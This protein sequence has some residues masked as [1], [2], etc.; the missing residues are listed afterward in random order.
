MKKKKEE[1]FNFLKTERFSILLSVNNL[2]NY[3]IKSEET[4]AKSRNSYQLLIAGFQIWRQNA[5][6]NSRL[7]NKMS[8]KTVY[9]LQVI[10]RHISTRNKD[11][12]YMTK[13]SRCKHSFEEV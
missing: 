9:L 11:L 4:R 7:L 3:I 2:E 1:E 8:A 12:L 5:F 6:H 10:F 13:V